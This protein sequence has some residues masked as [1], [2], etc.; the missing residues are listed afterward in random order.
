MTAILDALFFSLNKSGKN[1][2]LLLPTKKSNPIR[3]AICEQKSNIYVKDVC[4]ESHFGCHG[5]TIQITLNL[6]DA[7]H[8]AFSDTAS[9]SVD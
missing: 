5:V 9:S 4:F 8:K 6:P 7:R 2:I 3:Q 1:I